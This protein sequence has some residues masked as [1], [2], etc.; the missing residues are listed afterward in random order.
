[1]VPARTR[2][3]REQLPQLCQI[4][5]DSLR[6]GTDSMP[7]RIELMSNDPVKVSEQR[8]LHRQV[9][10]IDLDSSNVSSCCRSVRAILLTLVQL[11]F[12]SP[13]V[14]SMHSMTAPCICC[15]KLDIG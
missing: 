15:I 2:A 1:M 8:I 10:E 12:N 13:N 11:R 9:I 6:L 14:A 7:D 5:D 3:L 4:G